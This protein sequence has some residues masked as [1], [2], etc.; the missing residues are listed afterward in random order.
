MSELRLEGQGAN[1]EEHEDLGKEHS[2]ERKQQGQRPW[3]G[4]S[5]A[6]LREGPYA[7]ITEQRER[8]EQWRNTRLEARVSSVPSL[9]FWCSVSPPVQWSWWSLTAFTSQD[10]CKKSVPKSGINILHLMGEGTEIWKMTF[11][12]ITH[13]DSTESGLKFSS[14]DCYHKA[15]PTVL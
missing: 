2:R 5:L 12:E 1:L 3:G 8:R 9:T 11:S 7:S 13:F 10:L 6:Y 14:P 15:L 4:M